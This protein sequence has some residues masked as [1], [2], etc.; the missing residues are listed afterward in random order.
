MRKIY[1]Q[2]NK[3]EPDILKER[4]EKLTNITIK[5][6]YFIKIIKTIIISLE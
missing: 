1:K 2:N 5:S 3:N 6:A 4:F